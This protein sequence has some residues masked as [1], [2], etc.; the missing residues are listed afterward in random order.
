MILQ[1]LTVCWSFTWA[2]HLYM[3]DINKLRPFISSHHCLRRLWKTKL[4]WHILPHQQ[5][6][7]HLNMSDFFQSISP[8]YS[9]R[10][11]RKCSWTMC[12]WHLG[13]FSSENNVETF[14]DF[15]SEHHWCVRIKL[16]KLFLH[17]NTIVSSLKVDFLFILEVG[18]H[19][20]L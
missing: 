1:H 19:F 17:L 15:S 6:F 9:L 16:L 7:R 2:G 10:N 18:R 11:Q 3:D 8:N 13:H 12:C 4:E 14:I 5:L 20:A